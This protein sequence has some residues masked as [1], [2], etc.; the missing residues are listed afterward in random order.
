ME[1]FLG[2]A[3]FVIIVVVSVIVESARKVRQINWDYRVY[4]QN[5]TTAGI[6]TSLGNDKFR[7]IRKAFQNF[8]S[9]YNGH[10]V[11]G[12]FQE[13]PKVVF[14]YRGAKVLLS[15]HDTQTAESTLKQERERFYTRLTFKVRRG[16]PYRLE[17]FPQTSDINQRYLKIFDINVG[18]PD[19]DPK[20]VV[21]SNDENFAREFLDAGT[22]TAVDRLHGMPPFEGVI[23]SLNRERLIVSKTSIIHY[24]AVLRDFAREAFLLYDRIE[25]FLDRMSGL[26]VVSA[27]EEENPTCNVCGMPME[28]A[29]RVYCRRCKTP[30]HKDCWTYNGKCAVYGCGE[31]RTVDRY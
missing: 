6:K 8:A 2:L 23:L 9:E 22:K 27:G 15:I 12:T 5:A 17:I 1:C 11:G 4:N 19:F 26:E 13:A 14:T 25:Y 3:I 20:F 21:K 30:L 24:P 16:W 31:T 18:D 7:E 28:T 29:T 10:M